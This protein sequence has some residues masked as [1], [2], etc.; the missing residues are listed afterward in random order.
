MVKGGAAP[1]SISVRHCCLDDAVPDGEFDEA[2]PRAKRRGDLKRK[3]HKERKG[4]RHGKE[5]MR[6]RSVKGWRRSV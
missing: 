5:P 1:K 6:C 4:Q 2:M 3:A